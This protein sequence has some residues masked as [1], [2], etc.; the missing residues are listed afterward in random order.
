MFESI[1]KIFNIYNVISELSKTNPIFH[2]EQGFQDYLVHKIG[3]CYP[4]LKIKF[5][6]KTI[7]NEGYKSYINILIENCINMCSF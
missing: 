2:N 4:K 5:E 6:H 3:Q 1:S 7:L